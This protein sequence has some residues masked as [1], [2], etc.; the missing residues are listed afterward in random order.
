MPSAFSWLMLVPSSLRLPAPVNQGVRPC[1]NTRRGFVRLLS[2]VQ[3]KPLASCRI[4]LWTAYNIDGQAIR[5][6]FQ[7]PSNTRLKAESFIRVLLAIAYASFCAKISFGATPSIDNSFTFFC[8]LL[9]PL[10]LFLY[11]RNGLEGDNR[12]IAYIVEINATT[13]R[14]RLSDPRINFEETHYISFA[15]VSDIYIHQN[16]NALRQPRWVSIRCKDGQIF[17]LPWTGPVSD[18]LLNLIKTWI[19]GNP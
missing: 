13:K 11:L 6:E 17:H 16:V 5:V 19:D 1:S 10:L 12:F 14:I 2:L 7:R 9:S 8:F 3:M 4:G 18:E 15:D